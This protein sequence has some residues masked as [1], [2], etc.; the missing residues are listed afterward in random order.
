MVIGNPSPTA[1]AVCVF[2]SYEFMRG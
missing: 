1:A 2:C